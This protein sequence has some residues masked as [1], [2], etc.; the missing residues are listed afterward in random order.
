MGSHAHVH[1]KKT[2]T[3]SQ[4]K[5]LKPA[6][7]LFWI[8][9][10]LFSPKIVS[11]N[12]VVPFFSDMSAE[13]IAR[14]NSENAFNFVDSLVNHL[15]LQSFPSRSWPCVEHIFLGVAHFLCCCAIFSSP[16]SNKKAV[17]E[18]H[19]YWTTCR[20]TLPT[21]FLVLGRECDWSGATA[22]VKLPPYAPT[23]DRTMAGPRVGRPAKTNSTFH[24][25]L[26]ESTKRTCGSRPP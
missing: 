16:T 8:L 6:S 5:H 18:P 1:R 19:K 2:L 7:P 11:A 25:G 24:R 12:I 23:Q 20:P 21:V 14:R 13:P 10:F 9:H 26:A 4:I 3:L 15:S 17:I 22:P